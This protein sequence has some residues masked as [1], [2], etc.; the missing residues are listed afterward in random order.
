VAAYVWPGLEK[1]TGV[2]FMRSQIS[3]AELSDGTS[4]VI[5]LGE[6][7]LDRNLY[8]SGTSL[9]DDQSMYMGDDADIRR[10]TAFPPRLDPSYDEI[11]LF[12]S[13]HF[14]GCYVGLGDGSVRF[15][16]YQVDAELFRRLGNRRDGGVTMLSIP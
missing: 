8:F 9:G 11:Q 13:A 15:I 5:M 12:G 6:K 7:C 1:L 4:N 3:L 10:F 14:N 16:S 2:A